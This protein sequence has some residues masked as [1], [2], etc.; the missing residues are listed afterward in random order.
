MTSVLIISNGFQPNYEKAFANGLA[1]NGIAVTLV[2]SDRS[3]VDGLSVAITV[4]NLRGSQDPARSWWRKGTNLVRYVA[5]VARD[6]RAGD[7]D[8][9]H[10]AGLFVTRSVTAG[11]FELLAY[12][13]LARRVFMTVHNVLPH[14]RQGWRLRVLHR[15]IYLVPD[16][17][18]V[19]TP[20]MK[21]ALVENFGVAAGRVVVMAHGVD[22]VPATLTAP[23]PSERLR[24]LCFGALHPYKGV[25]LLLRAATLCREIPIQVTIVGEARHKSY[26]EEIEKLIGCMPPGHSVGWHRTYVEEDAVQGHFESADVV[27]MP[28]RQIDQSGVLF[29]AFRFGVPVIVTDVGA[30]RDFVPAYA[31]LIAERA[32]PESV[33]VALRQFYM[34]RAGFDREKIRLLARSLD[35]S[36][37]VAPL[38]RAYQGGQP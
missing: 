14:G 10:L 27:A 19:H 3:L 12:R 35:W 1:H 13:M 11:L 23:E 16:M 29:T 28:Y 22:A 4:R 20:K 30:F 37:T 24:I 15:L 17:L 31:G 33:A 38:M 18:V 26:A 21:E 9:L 2:A 32:Q 5:A 34:H 25:D 36:R 8:V 7:Y 6:I